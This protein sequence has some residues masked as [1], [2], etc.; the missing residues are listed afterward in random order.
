MLFAGLEPG[1]ERQD[2]LA[3]DAARLLDMDL[4]A[5]ALRCAVVARPAQAERGVEHVQPQTSL[6]SL[7][8]SCPRGS[9]D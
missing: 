4:E 7:R 3:V 5:R 6:R 8:K 2:E 1:L 9:G